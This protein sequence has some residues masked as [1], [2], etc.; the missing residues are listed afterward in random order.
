MAKKP[1]NLFG[2]TVEELSPVVS[3]KDNNTMINNNLT[4]TSSS[5][6]ISQE[7]TN[8]NVNQYAFD[9]ARQYVKI[10]RKPSIIMTEAEI[11]AI[12]VR[13]MLERAILSGHIGITRAANQSRM[14]KIAVLFQNNIQMDQMFRGLAAADHGVRAVSKLEVGETTYITMVDVKGDEDRVAV[15]TLNKMDNKVYYTARYATKSYNDRGEFG[16]V[17]GE[18]HPIGFSIQERVKGYNGWVDSFNFAVKQIAMG[19]T[20]PEQKNLVGGL[21]LGVEDPNIFVRNNSIAHINADSIM[22]K[23]MI[24][25]LLLLNVTVPAF[26]IFTRAKSVESMGK[27]IDAI[28]VKGEKAYKNELKKLAGLVVYGQTEEA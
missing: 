24:E 5:S 27:F 2:S 1:L 3:N 16:I 26:E 11:E 6:V 20:T 4:N 18:V 7:N 13:A 22:N 14:E 21:S 25:A 8:M 23:Y 10:A 9:N 15:G 19:V 28:I 17:T 12:N